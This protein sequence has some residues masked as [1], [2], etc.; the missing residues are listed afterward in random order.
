MSGHTPS[1]TSVDQI[2]NIPEAQITPSREDLEIEIMER[3]M[4][5]LEWE[6]EHPPETPEP[7]LV[8]FQEELF[9]RI[10][11]R[12]PTPDYGDMPD[13]DKRASAFQQLK[14][15]NIL[16]RHD[17]PA[18]L[19]KTKVN[20]WFST[21]NVDNNVI[22]DYF[23]WY[24]E[25]LGCTYFIVA[26]ENAPTTG[27]EHWHGYWEFHQNI[28][29][30]QMALIDPTACW[31]PARGTPLQAFNYVT[32]DGNIVKE[33]GQR[34]VQVRMREKARQR[35]SNVANLTFKDMSAL[36]KS[37]QYTMEQIIDQPI[38]ARYQRFFDQLM[39]AN[40]TPQIYAG[41]LKQKNY[42]IW[43]EAGTGKSRAVWEGAINHHLSV[44]AKGQNKWWD[45]FFDQ[46]V[47]VIE[48][49]NPDKM[50]VLVDHMKVWTDRYPF[51]AEI[52]GSSK[53]VNNP[54]FKFIV[55]S[56]YDID[57]CFNEA[58]LP[59]LKRRFT[60]IEWKAEGNPD[61]YEDA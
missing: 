40:T 17:T 24:A 35:Q 59:A 28:H 31:E 1:L 9:T 16:I 27:H 47:I 6:D 15:R 57:Q 14:E 2:C 33:F 29:Y 12:A 7:S 45:G 8:P 11:P 18:Q 5:M 58:D 26:K 13:F 23:E 44:Y 54:S 25:Q 48:D 34:P 19:I 4:E 61:I 39:A 52:K 46:Q 32:K 42:W 30:T 41:D 43:G 3:E 53:V 60:V 51:Y 38:Y 50:R 22:P 37:K 55:T 21:H 20:R 10:P 49:A 36:I 56:N